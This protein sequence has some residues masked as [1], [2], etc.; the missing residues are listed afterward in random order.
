M[1]DH[2]QLIHDL[3][4]AAGQAHPERR[5]LQDSAG[6]LTYADLTDAVHATAQWLTAHGVQAGDRVLVRLPPGRD[7]VRL[8]YGCSWIGATL[9][10]VSPSIGP[11]H[12]A[13][14]VEDAEPA[15]I[16][17]ELPDDFASAPIVPAP[18]PRH[19]PDAVALLIYTSGSTAM[20]KAVVCTH[21]QVVFATRAIAEVVDYRPDDVVYCR[22]PF[23][24]DY[25][26]YQVLLCA[27]AG[28]CLV[29]ADPA[30]G[31]RI[32]ADIRA[33]RATVV[34]LV[35]TLAAMLVAIAGRDGAEHTVRLFTN[36]GEWLAS[37]LID[38]LRDSFPAAAVQLMYG[39]TE[40][41][42]ISVLTPDGDRDRPGSVG[43]PLPGTT[44]AIV[45]DD[46]T[47]LPAGQDG[48]ITVSGAHVMSGYWRAPALTAR[49]FRTTAAGIVLHT[50]DQGR[51]DEDGYLYLLGRRDDIFKLNGVR[52]SVTEI[53][54]IA[55]GLSGV[56]QAAVVPPDQLRQATLCLVTEGDRDAV[57]GELA[58]LLEPARTPPV[59]VFLDR[60]PTNTSGKLDRTTL[61][62]EVTG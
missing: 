62:R 40:C 27:A 32:L 39:T 49:T 31:P 34:P 50:G 52:T 9:I 17:T 20:P 43:R 22:L 23:S 29:I 6:A 7:V 10:P 12:W 46:G 13:H 44:V 3:L 45:D 47:P 51:L 41:K 25:G 35:P 18:S 59:V 24:F 19:D 53:E 30:A 58:T 21:R 61:R 2:D 14:V 38:R 60:L 26:L 57:L 15:L 4:I 16:L 5:A 1:P 8:L 36:T 42:R 37:A 48:E 56:T 55:A 33:C 28:A 54:A 11:T